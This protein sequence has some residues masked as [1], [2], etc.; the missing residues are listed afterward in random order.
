MPIRRLAILSCGLVLALG[1]CGPFP[2]ADAAMG[3]EGASAPAP[4]LLPIDDLLAQAQGGG[5]GV[6]SAAASDGAL[7]AR[8]AALNAR[9]AA[10]RRPVT[11]PAT[12][13]RLG[14]AVPDAAALVAS[15]RPSG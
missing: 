12:R 1:A 4:D 7:A 2:Q 8:V 6:A 3:R 13:A 5:P 9:A 15:P 11:D 14:R 10:L